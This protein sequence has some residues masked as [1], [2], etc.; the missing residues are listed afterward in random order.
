MPGQQPGRL[1]GKIAI[2]TGAASGIGAAS[3][4]R[5]AQEGAA[6]VIADVRL[7]VARQTAAA[8]TA[9]GRILCRRRG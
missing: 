5:F 4:K 3:A 6:V 2:I 9:G 1:D 8:I 7:D